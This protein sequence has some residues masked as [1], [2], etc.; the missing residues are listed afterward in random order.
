MQPLSTIVCFYTS[1][2]SSDV[3]YKYRFFLKAYFKRASRPENEN[4]QSRWSINIDPLPKAMAAH[5]AYILFVICLM[6]FIGH[7]PRW[8][9]NPTPR[10]F[11]IYRSRPTYC[12]QVA[13]AKA[14]RKAEGQAGKNACN[15]GAASRALLKKYKSLSTDHYSLATL[16]PD[17]NNYFL[18]AGE[19]EYSARH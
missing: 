9:I 13:R 6:F 2:P 10:I 1:P 3:I 15:L 5:Q 11:S 17:S 8:G 7:F 16:I 18:S 4:K 19:G 12:S 14:R